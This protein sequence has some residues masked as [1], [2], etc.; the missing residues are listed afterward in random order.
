MAGAE[1]GMSGAGIPLQPQPQPPAAAAGPADESSDSEGEHEGPQKLIRKVSTSGQIRSKVRGAGAGQPRRFHGWFLHPHPKAGLARSW[2]RPLHPSRIPGSGGGGGGVCET[3]VPLPS[4]PLPSSPSSCCVHICPRL[5]GRAPRGCGSPLGRRGSCLPGA[6]ALPCRA[7]WV[8][9]KRRAASFPPS[10]LPSGSSS[11]AAGTAA[12]GIPPCHSAARVGWLSEPF[13]TT[14][15]TRR[16]PFFSSPPVPGTAAVRPARAAGTEPAVARRAP[17][18]ECRQGEKG[19][20]HFE[21]RLA[22][23]EV[24]FY[25]SSL[26]ALDA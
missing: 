3:T 4:F 1:S 10:L 14:S 2:G 20:F 15:H 24:N 26:V 8:W 25:T 9:G 18:R 5:A 13:L 16:P 22:E 21:R 12:A 6:A 11:S 17:L 19:G 7:S 23:R